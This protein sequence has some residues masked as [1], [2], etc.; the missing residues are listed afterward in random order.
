MRTPSILV[1]SAAAWALPLMVQAAP[2]P[3]APAAQE[4]QAPAPKGPDTV[5]VK[6]VHAEYGDGN[7]ETVVQILEDY[8]ARHDHYRVA[9]S[10]VIAKYLGVIYAANPDSREKG[11]YWLY[12][13]LQLDP[14]QDLVD[15]Y[16]GE[17]VQGVFDKV[18]Q[19]FVVRRNYRGI[20]DTRLNKAIAEGEPPKRDTVVRK[21]TVV[22]K[23]NYLAP[24][25]S[26]I[27]EGVKGGYSELKGGI[28]AG[29]EAGYVPIKEEAKPDDNSLTGNLNVGAGLKFLNPDWEGVTGVTDQTEIRATVDFRQRKWPINVAFHYGY[30]FGPETYQQ[31]PGNET[32]VAAQT[33]VMQEMGFGVRKIFDFRL[34]TVRPF[35]GGGFGYSSADWRV[36]NDELGYHFSDQQGKV[37]I[38]LNGGVYWE[39]N[40]HFNIG[41]DWMYTWAKIHM[42]RDL[43][44]G[45]QH[46]DMILGFHL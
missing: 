26:P 14:G 30:A 41:L 42:F 18:R 8:R 43:N 15:L 5:D 10:V 2:A 21:D 35:F 17:E 28:K 27:A 4:T 36:D 24:I 29:I 7:F 13:M 12:R 19:E 33:I 3:S 9:D 6:R 31:V 25:V 46:L 44:P 20:N 1:F 22:V 32:A 23:D 11:K 45:G 39:L 34:Y 40:R 38:W 37:G 16:V